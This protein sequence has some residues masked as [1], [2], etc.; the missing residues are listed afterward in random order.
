MKE[1]NLSCVDEEISFSK[2]LSLAARSPRI[3]CLSRTNEWEVV[4]SSLQMP[5]Y[6]Y[7]VENTFYITPNFS[8]KFLAPENAKID[9]DASFMYNF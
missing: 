9:W 4:I 5:S 8:S 3:F 2:L 1:M 6:E 7:I